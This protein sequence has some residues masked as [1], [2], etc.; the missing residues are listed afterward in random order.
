MYCAYFTMVSRYCV[1]AP[2][3][4]KM[5]RHTDIFPSQRHCTIEFN[6]NIHHYIVTPRAITAVNLKHQF[7][8]WTTMCDLNSNYVKYAGSIRTSKD[9]S[10]P[11]KKKLLIIFCK[12]ILI[13][14]NL[15][16]FFLTSIKEMKVV[17]PKFL[18]SI[19]SQDVKSLTNHGRGMITPTRKFKVQPL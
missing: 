3:M 11:W 18:S 7:Y 9:L 13:K 6:I 8:S 5:T 1:Q 15:F 4:R 10:K 12:V 2:S 17:V 14:F 16:L 19:S